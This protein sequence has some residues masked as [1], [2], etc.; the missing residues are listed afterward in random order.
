MI[1][2]LDFFTPIVDDPYDF[3]A[4]AAAN[5]MSDIYA[6]GGRVTLALNICAF[7]PNMPDGIAGQILQ[8]GADKVLEAGGFI[9]G[10]HTIDD[11]EPKYGLSVMGTVHPERFL[12]KSGASAGDIII[13]T[14]ALG[15]GMIT[16]AA[17]GGEAEPE[18]I[19]TAVESMKQLNM[20]ASAILGGTASACTDV[21]GF[22]LIG[23][24]NE[25]ASKSGLALEIESSK[26]PFIS[27]A[28]RY[29]DEWLFPAGSTNN[30]NCYKD[31]VRLSGSVS[32][33]IEMLLYTPETS[34]GLL[35]AVKSDMANEVLSMFS[36]SG[37]SAWVI[38]KA[39]A[40]SG[41]MIL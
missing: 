1:Q 28:V 16:T 34:G 5:A 30:R 6:M 32:E 20:K 39:A 8:G 22:S 15:S 21:T 41:I 23:H 33:E 7:P 17:K 14:K 29:A 25:I 2:T 3:G 27:G 19:D 35:A 36:E 31:L 24:A 11:E 4:I 13:L 9:A 18:H 38:G 12:G 10:G 37:C 40:G 26:I